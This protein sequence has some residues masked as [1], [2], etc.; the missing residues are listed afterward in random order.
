MTVTGLAADQAD[1][2]VII[3]SQKCIGEGE[4]LTVAAEDPRINIGLRGNGK[5][6][7][8]WTAHSLVLSRRVELKLG[9]CE[10]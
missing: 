3:E 9:P 7:A 6:K 8:D 4:R 10:Q 2:P 1:V 5:T